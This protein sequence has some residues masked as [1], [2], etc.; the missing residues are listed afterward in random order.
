MI[1]NERREVARSRTQRVRLA[2]V[3]ICGLVLVVASLTPA[4]ASPSPSDR[5]W[6]GSRWWAKTQGLPLAT[7][8]GAWNHP[9]SRSATLDVV[10]GD[11]TQSRTRFVG[12]W[13]SPYTARNHRAR[14]VSSWNLEWIGSG[15]ARGAVVIQFRYRG[16]KGSWTPWLGIRHRLKG[17]S[18]SGA[19]THVSSGGRRG[20]R[21]FEW[22]VSGVLRSSSAFGGSFSMTISG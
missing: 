9:D 17:P 3:A 5:A 7:V 11:V 10:G 12:I 18:D 19:G 8:V 2:G 22:R 20:A 1:C 4:G 16:R 15:Q 6:N 13:R 21:Q 14:A